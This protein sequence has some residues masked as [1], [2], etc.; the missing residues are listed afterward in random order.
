MHSMVYAITDQAVPIISFLPRGR[1]GIKTV[2]MAMPLCMV[3]FA[4]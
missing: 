2:D 3:I 4:K 1:E